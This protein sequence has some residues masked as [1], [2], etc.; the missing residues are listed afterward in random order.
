MRKTQHWWII[1]SKEKT[2]AF[3][4]CFSLQPGRDKRSK[5]DNVTVRCLVKVQRP[6]LGSTHLMFGNQ[7]LVPRGW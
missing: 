7:R 2:V 5:N 3:D 6:R 4:M 1:I